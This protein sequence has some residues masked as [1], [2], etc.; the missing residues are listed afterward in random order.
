MR[1]D[2]YYELTFI[3][4]IGSISENLPIFIQRKFEMQAV[5][6]LCHRQKLEN[7]FDN[8]FAENYVV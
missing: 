5:I 7:A 2:S 6:Y 4:N 8:K 1:V 3:I